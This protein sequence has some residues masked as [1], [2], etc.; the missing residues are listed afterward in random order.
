MYTLFHS[1]LPSLPFPQLDARIAPSQK[2][3]QPPIYLPTGV[4]S[5]LPVYSDCVSQQLVE[6]CNPGRDA[7]V[8]RAVAH[9]N[10]DAAQ[11]LGIDLEK[12]T[13]SCR[14]ITR[15]EET[16]AGWDEGPLSL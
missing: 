15:I 3:G 13:V 5:L 1:S 16:G 14:H 2:P 8:D 6:F 11:D 10:D 12:E 4:Q 7:V 9:L